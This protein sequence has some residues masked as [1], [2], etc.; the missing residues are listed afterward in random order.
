VRAASRNGA[1]R[2]VVARL[3]DGPLDGSLVHPPLSPEGEPADMLPVTEDRDGAYVL[4]GSPGSR[5]V[6]PYRWITAQEWNGLRLWLR[7]RRHADPVGA[8]PQGRPPRP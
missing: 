4:A 6:V 2:H 7:F 5:G 1:S 3:Q 8:P